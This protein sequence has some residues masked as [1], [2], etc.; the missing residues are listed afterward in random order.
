[1]AKGAAPKAGSGNSPKQGSG[2][3]QPAHGSQEVV[4][5][6]G[7]ASKIVPSKGNGSSIR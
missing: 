2:G 5:S 1:M 3:V 6:G 7:M 4:H